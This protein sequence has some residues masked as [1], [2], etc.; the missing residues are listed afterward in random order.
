MQRYLPYV[1]G[2]KE[3]AEPLPLWIVPNR[4]VSLSDVMMCMRD[5]YEGTPFSLD[6]DIGGC[7]IVLHHYLSN[8]KVR[9]VSM[10]VL[11][12]PSSLHLSM[13]VKCVLGYLVK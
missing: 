9:H 12:A 8:V 13:S 4:K 5:H 10:N 11:L 6:G 2:K 1:E 7:L 3:G